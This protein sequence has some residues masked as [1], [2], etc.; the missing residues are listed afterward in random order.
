MSS[1]TRRIGWIAGF[2]GAI[3]ISLGSL[4]T[5]LMYTGS[6]G[7]AY[8]IFNHFVSE[9]GHT[10]VSQG[11]LLF[12]IA[13][14][15]GAICLG[16]HLVC[17]AQGFEGGLR[18]TLAV[19]AVIVGTFGMLVGFF[20]MNVSGIHYWVA[21]IF[22]MASAVYLGIFTTR[23]WRT[24][25]NPYPKWLAYIGLPMAL[26]VTVL[27]ITGVV[28]LIQGENAMAQAASTRAGFLLITTSEWFTIMSMILWIVSVSIFLL[29]SE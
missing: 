20:P 26:S 8:S 18:W 9:L 11:A 15:T 24:P 28:N 3:I 1:R 5:A 14:I 16:V 13:L 12:N 21:A 2:A 25:A 29:S 7:E 22:F 19:V 23:V 27:L 6:D 10:E 4:I 17:V